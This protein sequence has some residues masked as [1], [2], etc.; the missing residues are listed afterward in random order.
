M[1]ADN[2]SQERA[3]QRVWLSAGG[4]IAVLVVIAMGLTLALLWGFAREQNRAYDDASTRLVESA[5]NARMR[6]SAHVALDYAVWNDAYLATTLR[7]DS[8]W[9]DNNYYSNIADGVFVVRADGEVRHAWLAETQES[10]REAITAGIVDAVRNEFNLGQLLS[11]AESSGMTAT[12][13]F[14]LAGHPVLLSVA[15]ISPEEHTVRQ[16]RNADR[17]VDYLAAI[18]VITPA[19]LVEIGQGIQLHELEFVEGASRAS[20]RRLVMAVGSAGA[21]PV[22]HLVWRRERPGSATFLSNAGWIVLALLVVGAAALLVARRM[23]SDHIRVDA[24]MRGA[25]EANRIKS[26][27]ISTMSHE[28]RTPLN[29]I[30]GYTELIQEEAGDLGEAGAAINEDAVRV[31]AAARHLG[32]LVNDV[33]DQSRI[34]AGK[35]AIAIEA[36]EVEGVIA[37]VE[38][39]MRPLAIANGNAFR[40]EIEA[41]VGD[42]MADPMRLQQ[43]LINLTGNAH[44]FTKRGTVTLRAH[45]MADR[46]GAF[47]RF[48]IADTGIGMERAELERLFKPFAQANKGIA[49]KFGGTG[50]GLSIT[51]S[52][53]RAMGGEVFAESKPG[54]GSVFSLVLPAP[55]AAASNVMPLVRIA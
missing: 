31:I 26:E 22:G 4:P 45:R 9:V 17:P 14:A 32:R 46:N 43:C 12:T 37:E 25:R 5:L 18:D 13:T 52:L 3:S 42:V 34:D 30:V 16:A 48:Q 35:L 38:E 2:S 20:T 8:E 33:L 50:L 15:P 10:E 51:R 24:E 53:T 55:A 1:D 39:L 7:W 19:E 47:V 41:G 28:L 36:V 49:S 23:V 11:A 29:A 27:F 54:T 40:I 6:A 21:E 44:K